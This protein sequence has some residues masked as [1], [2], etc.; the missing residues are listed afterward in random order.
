M[1]CFFFLIRYDVRNRL[2]DKSQFGLKPNLAHRM[3][4]EERTFQEQLNMERYLALEWDE[5]RVEEQEGGL[6][7]EFI[8]LQAFTAT[9]SCRRGKKKT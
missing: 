9:L 2:E 3:S 6:Y 8:N 5:I 4:D 7:L 1:S